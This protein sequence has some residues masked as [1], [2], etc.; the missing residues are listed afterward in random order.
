MA[1][2]DFRSAAFSA[3]RWIDSQKVGSPVIWGNQNDSISQQCDLY[4]GNS[5]T[6]LFYLELYRETKSE[7]YLRR[8]REGACLLLN[9]VD[10][11]PLFGFYDGVA[12]VAFALNEASVYC[13][14]LGQ[15]AV[16]AVERLK[17]KARKASAGVEWNSS[18]DLI[19]GNAGIGLVLVELSKKLNRPDLLEL[20]KQAA[21]KLCASRI[22]NSH[23][24]HWERAS[25]QPVNYPNFSHGTAGVGYFLLRL[26]EQSKDLIYLEAAREAADYLESIAER[27]TGRECLIFHDDKDKPVFYLGWCHGPAGT[28]Q[29][30]LKLYEIT[31]TLRYFEFVEKSARTL[32]KSGIPEHETPGYWNNLSRCC[33]AAGVGEWMLGF[34]CATR[35]LEYLEFARRIG[36]HLQNTASAEVDGIKWVQAENRKEPHEVIA[37]TGLMQGAAGIGLYLLHLQSEDFVS[38]RNRSAALC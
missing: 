29:F 21:D 9:Q 20:A 19:S 5:G 24:W 27:A 33:G 11:L 26:Y 28:S 3:E 16:R 31:G 6:I 36:R 32:M 14:E 12:G 17:E 4:Y 23:G 13:P 35:R 30:F 38:S 25:D 1:E 2:N 18:N 22:I 34:Y 7:V 8:I 37:Q 10:D 15:I